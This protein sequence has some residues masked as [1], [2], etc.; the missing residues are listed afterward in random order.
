MVEETA[1]EK[2]FRWT[3][4]ECRSFNKDFP[5]VNLLLKSAMKALR[6]RGVLYQSC[7][8]ELVQIR[9]QSLVR[10]FLEALTRGGPGGTPKPIELHAHDPLR[11]VG[12]MLA[13]LHQSAAGDRELFEVMFDVKRE[14]V[15]LYTLSP[16]ASDASESGNGEDMSDDE[17]LIV[18]ILDNSIEGLCRPLKVRVEQVLVS[19]PDPSIAYKIGNLIQFYSGVIYKVLGRESQLAGVLRELRELSYR[20][21]FDLLNS[22]GAKVLRDVDTPSMDLLPSPAVKETLNMMKVVLSTYD[23]SLLTSNR[24]ISSPKPIPSS[25]NDETTSSTNEIE[26][27]LKAILDPLIQMSIMGAAK[28]DARFMTTGMTS[29]NNVNDQ[30][31]SPMHDQI[32]ASLEGAIYMVNCLHT[33]QMALSVYPFTST[34]VEVIETQ[35]EA[36][37]DVLVREQYGFITEQSG[38]MMILEAMKMYQQGSANTDS[39]LSLVTGLDATSLKSALTQF[40]QFLITVTLDVSSTLARIMSSRVVHVVSQRGFKM[41]LEAYKKLY[42]AVMDPSNKYEFPSTLMTRTVEE[43]ET[44]IG[45]E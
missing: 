23:E 45:V 2:L 18:T 42:E 22:W 37:V 30:L 17:Q 6:P 35:I 33:I 1:Y 14:N 10:S 36:Y 32:V 20:V 5:E 38:L 3:Q 25:G 34:R 29:P 43:V 11:Y 4:Q 27:I 28:L 41:F 39:P 40:D 13:W 7:I 19:Q 21:F 26:A 15:R 24:S 8:D 31:P 16:L 12:D 44:L 9:R